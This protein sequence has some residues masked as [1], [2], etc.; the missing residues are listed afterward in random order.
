M[1]HRN[2]EQADQ[3][4]DN[5]FA[6]CVDRIENHL[7]VLVLC[8]DEKVSF[9]LPLRYLPE[10]AQEG[11]YL[12]LMIQPDQ[13][14]TLAAQERIATLQKELCSETEEQTNIKL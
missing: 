8:N 6:V 7:A 1:T 5:S 9:N 4:T 13:T 3:P 2:K 14:G 10:G 12:R 11:D